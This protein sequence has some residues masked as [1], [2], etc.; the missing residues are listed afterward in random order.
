MLDS[1]LSLEE[2]P[3]CHR[4]WK[5]LRLGGG[6]TSL[7]AGRAIPTLDGAYS[8]RKGELLAE[9]GEKQGTLRA[10]GIGLRF[11]F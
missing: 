5:E 9:G 6:M 10:L 11:H 2:L 8:S 7:W 3:P 1:S 4:T